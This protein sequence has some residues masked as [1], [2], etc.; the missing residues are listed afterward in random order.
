MLDVSAAPP[1]PFQ[2]VLAYHSPSL[3]RA[4]QRILGSEDLAWDA[5]QETL[6]ALWALRRTPPQPRAWLLRAVVHRSLH[7]RRSLQRRSA[8]EQR[9]A[10]ACPLCTPLDPQRALANAD[11]RA[12][13]REALAE[14][15]P[16]Q[17]EVFLLY[18]VEQLEYEAIAARLCVPVGTVRSR[19]NRAR[20]A[21]RRHLEGEPAAA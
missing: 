13:L 12:A 8:Y 19:L 17:R 16:A 9:A 5:V 2:D 7:L 4:A 3:L 15:N 11:L 21:L 20:Q 14:L 1:A 10:Q 18:E 6:L